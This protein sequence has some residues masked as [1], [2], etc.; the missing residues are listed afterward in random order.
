LVLLSHWFP[1]AERA[2]ANAYW[3]LC[4]PAAVIF[5]GP[6]SGWI[7]THWNW[8]VLLASEGAMPFVWLAFWWRFIDDHPRQAKWIS[9]P[10]R[11]YLESTVLQESA[12]LDSVWP[13]PFLRT[14]LRPRVL[15]L[16]AIH[17]LQASGGY[18]FLFWLPSALKSI[19][20]R[21]DQ[22]VGF[23]ATAPYV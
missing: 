16:A 1:L 11:V 20:N 23:L 14:L 2:R 8:R 17:I 10:E 7:L 3:M 18:G 9:A 15:L 4:Q 5:S 19:G 6:L 22:L 13:E 12:E 21:S